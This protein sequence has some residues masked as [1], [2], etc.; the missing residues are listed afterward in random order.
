[1][2][3]KQS[4]QVRVQPVGASE[5]HGGKLKNCQS[6]TDAGI[7]ADIN[8]KRRNGKRSKSSKSRKSMGS[9]G[10]LDDGRDDR[11]GSAGSKKSD[12]SGLGDLGEYN[13]GF[14][15]ENSDPSK[16]RE[17]EENFREREDL[18]LAVTGTTLPTRNSA[19]DKARLEE[20]MILQKLR[21]EGLISKPNTEKKSGVS[22]EIVEMNPASHGSKLPAL[23][24][25]KL[26]KIEKRRK[27]KRVLTEEEIQ[28]KLER[29]EERRKRKEKARLEKI[30]EMDKADQTAAL[31]S[32]QDYQKKKEEQVTQK[33]DSVSDNRERRLREIKEKQLERERRREEV[34]RRKKERLEMGI[35]ESQEGIGENIKDASELLERQETP[36]VPE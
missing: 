10:S 31:E 8:D 13:H 33:M 6:E 14:I 24:P 3:C 30:K 25:L 36:M 18:D 16:V 9:S 4:K 19:K 12:D 20:S 22:F 27:K 2:G 15:T 7:E 1:M 21:E 23:P 28:Q 5:M 26:A 32:F 34:R 17:V 11:G 29:A 35:T